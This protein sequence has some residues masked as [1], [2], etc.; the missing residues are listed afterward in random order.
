MATTQRKYSIEQL[1]A[2]IAR[3]KKRA[4]R[5]K[6]YNSEE[7]RKK[8]VA[9]SVYRYRHRVQNESFGIFDPT[10]AARKKTYQTDEE[11]QEAKRARA[12]QFMKMHAEQ[13]RLASAA[14]R[15]EQRNE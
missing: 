4:G 15:Y 11:R 3:P 7:E 8:A 2:E 10:F 12:K 5:P 14:Y 1:E 6:K 9:E 13:H